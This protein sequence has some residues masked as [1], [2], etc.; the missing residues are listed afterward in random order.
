[1]IFVQEKRF[2]FQIATINAN[3]KHLT[4]SSPVTMKCMAAFLFS[5]VLKFCSKPHFHNA[6]VLGPEATDF[7]RRNTRLCLPETRPT[8]KGQLRRVGGATIH[9]PVAALH[10]CHSE[11]V[12]KRRDSR[13][14]SSHLSAGA[15]ALDS[16]RPGY[17][18]SASRDSWQAR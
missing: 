16:T 11:K 5:L 4:N 7:L 12:V 2:Q 17:S 14:S 9:A 1:M 18:D 10:C 6:P 15:A 3:C 8:D 13:P